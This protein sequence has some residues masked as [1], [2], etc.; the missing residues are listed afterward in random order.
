MSEENKDP[1]LLDEVNQ[2]MLDSAYMMWHRSD[3]GP[4][5]DMNKKCLKR[6]T[7][8]PFVISTK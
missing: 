2:Y 4:N 5:Q 7:E 1:K 3:E 6:M 8:K